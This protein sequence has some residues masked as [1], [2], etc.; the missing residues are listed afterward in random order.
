MRSSKTSRFFFLILVVVIVGAWFGWQHF[1]APTSKPQRANHM[2]PP[3]GGPPAGPERRFGSNQ[4]S[5]VYAGRA[6]NSDASV[7]IDALGTIKANASVTVTSQYYW[8]NASSL[9]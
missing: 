3:G 8:R 2:G 7:Y 4:E 9:L 5:P 1:H 6:K